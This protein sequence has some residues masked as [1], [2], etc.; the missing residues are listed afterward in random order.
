[1]TTVDSHATTTVLL[2][3]QTACPGAPLSPSSPR[4]NSESD[5][6]KSD[7]A[8]QSWGLSPL[9]AESTDRNL[10]FGE[11]LMARKGPRVMCCDTRGRG[12]GEVGIAPVKAVT[13]EATSYLI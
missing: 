7:E 8:T 13:N 9:G 2:P 12:R 1:M 3:H 6:A 5:L 11:G 10:P 4:S